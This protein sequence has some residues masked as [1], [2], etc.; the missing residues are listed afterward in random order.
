MSGAAPIYDFHTHSLYSDG[1]LLPVELVRR[2]V[3]NGYTAMAITD[4]VG[5]G[6]CEEV[7]S[8]LIV[9]CEACQKHM[10]I[11][12]I[13]GAEL[14]HVPASL[15]GTIAKQARDAG[16]KI[17]VVHGETLA[18]PVQPGTNLAALESPNVDLLAHPGLI[19]LEEARLAAERGIYLELSCRPGHSLSNGHVAKMARLAGARLLVDTDSHTPGDLLKPGWAYKV[20]TG[21]GLEAEEVERVLYCHPLDLMGKLGFRA[22]Q[23]SQLG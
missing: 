3:V 8:K 10:G 17:V 7:I 18:E 16:A 1:V 2:A 14:T 23:S 5:P 21:A 15:I 19:T 6:N 13:P 4:H 9:D 11:T 22:P 12:V 20:A